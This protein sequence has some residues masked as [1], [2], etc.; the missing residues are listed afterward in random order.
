MH[1]WAK[2]P[3]LNSSGIYSDVSISGPG[4]FKG[5]SPVL[6]WN[7]QYNN[8]Q[9]LNLPSV[10][11]ENTNYVINYY[12]SPFNYLEIFTTVT[13]P[14]ILQINNCPPM[15]WYVK[16]SGSLDVII[17]PQINQ[18]LEYDSTNEYI[19]TANSYNLV[20]IVPGVPPLINSLQNPTVMSLN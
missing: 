19:I 16:N 12:Q 5:A 8:N 13:N 9:P 1:K 6:N 14:Q 11:T 15:W 17:S 20:C 18:S 7:L 4:Q 10:T 3:L 2:P